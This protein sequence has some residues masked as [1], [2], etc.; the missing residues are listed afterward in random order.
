MCLN[1]QFLSLQFKLNN[2]KSIRDQNIIYK[3]L[4]LSSMVM[5]VKQNKN[6][7]HKNKCKS[8]SI[9]TD[10]LKP[11]DKNVINTKILKAV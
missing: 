4:P 3:R 6:K 1:L 10:V 9:N 11:Y 5:S 8:Y 7:T 2:V